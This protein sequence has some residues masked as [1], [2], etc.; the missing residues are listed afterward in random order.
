C[1]KPA[2]PPALVFYFYFLDPDLGL[3]H[4]RMPTVF[5]FAIQ[6]AVNGHD[7]LACQLRKAGVG[8]VQE[9]NAFTH[10]DDMAKAQQLADHFERERWPKRL[11]ALA[12]QVN[13]LMAD[14]LKDYPYYWVIDQ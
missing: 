5:P 10:I 8:F 1:F 9:D 11:R 6:I 2:K 12:L 14:V 7:Y 3:I 13:P 4:V